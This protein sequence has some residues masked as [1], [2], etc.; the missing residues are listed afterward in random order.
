MAG[1]FVVALKELMEE[2]EARFQAQLKPKSGR[3][4]PNLKQGEPVT[5]GADAPEETAKDT[6]RPAPEASVSLVF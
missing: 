1:S 5:G 3:G 4:A 6:A 2:F